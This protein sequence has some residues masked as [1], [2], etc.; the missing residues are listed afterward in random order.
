MER[1]P[2]GVGVLTAGVDVQGD[3]LEIQ[4]VGW[5]KGEESY[6]VEHLLLHG[7]PAKVEVWGELDA[8]LA[9]KY[10]HENGAKLTIAS[11]CVDTGGH[12]TMEV[13]A[14]CKKRVARRV[15]AIKGVGGEG[16]AIVSRPS[17]KNKGNVQLFTLGVDSIKDSI[18]ARLRIEEPGPGYY[19]F[20]RQLDEEFF[21]QLTAEKI[22]TKY[23]KGKPTRTWV[24][25]RP[26]NDGLDGNVYAVAALHILNADLDILADKLQVKT[27]EDRPVK[28][29][30]PKRESNWVNNW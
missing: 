14:Y 11:T 22:T 2:A 18:Y 30:A 1:L 25:T 21:R 19:H 16:R 20:S 7:D 8:A 12:H 27:E 4:I 9:K 26:R 24:Q 17:K 6:I 5:G 28:K 3:R 13:Y 10:N 29:V 15:W 23:V